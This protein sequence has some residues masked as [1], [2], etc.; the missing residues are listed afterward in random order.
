MLLISLLGMEQVV[1]LLGCL[2]KQAQ[3]AKY[4]LSIV[5]SRGKRGNRVYTPHGHNCEFLFS[6]SIR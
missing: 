1:V 5:Y 2:E 4:V 3:L 6:P